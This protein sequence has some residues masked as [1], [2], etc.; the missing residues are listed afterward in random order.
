MYYSYKLENFFR[1]FELERIVFDLQL[2]TT[3]TTTTT[4]T[5]YS[6][7]H[8]LHSTGLVMN[9]DAELDHGLKKA[10]CGLPVPWKEVFLRCSGVFSNECRLASDK[11][12]SAAMK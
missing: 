9:E 11:I 3:S 2:L 6:I 12:L 4:S 8:K 1:G 5:V 10:G 7:K